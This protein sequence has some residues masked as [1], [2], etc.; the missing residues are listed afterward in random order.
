MPRAPKPYHAYRV[1]LTSYAS[2][3]IKEAVETGRAFITSPDQLVSRLVYSGPD[4]RTAGARFAQACKQ[5]MTDPLAYLVVMYR[6]ND[7]V[8]RVRPE[9]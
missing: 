4:E 7:Q 8:A 9:R 3:Q 1:Y 5:A 6:D 2:I